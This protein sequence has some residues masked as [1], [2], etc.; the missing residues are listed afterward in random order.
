MTF[1]EN[2]LRARRNTGLL[3]TLYAAAVV[4]IICTIYLALVLILQ[5]T[6]QSPYAHQLQR[7]R[8]PALWH[9]QLFFTISVLTLTIILGG[10]L[11]KVWQLSAGG[12]EVAKL[13]G[14]RLIP[15]DTS[16]ANEK[17]VL[18]VVE[19]MS[20]AS[21][22]PVPAV[23][24]LAE[25]EEINAFAAGFST[26]DAVVAV[27]N[28][29]IQRL[30]RDE[31]QGVVAH[32]FSHILNGDMRLNLRLMG[33]L[34][35]ILMIALTGRGLL[36]ISRLGRHSRRAANRG[37]AFVAL[38]GFS[39]W[40]IG[41]IGAVFAQIIK[42]AVSRQRE[43]LADA[44][45]LQ[46]TRNPAGI[47][48]ALRKIAGYGS[49]LRH[50]NSEEAGHFFFA[51]GL[52][53][54]FFNLFATHPPILERIRRIDPRLLDKREGLVLDIKETKV[55][56]GLEE[57]AQKGK[58]VFSKLQPGDIHRTVGLVKAGHLDLARSL[59]AGLPPEIGK[60]LYDPDGARLVIYALLLN[61]DAA[62]RG[63]QITYLENNLTFFQRQNFRRVAGLVK[64]LGPQHRLP[65]ASAS[66]SA[67]R[68]L[69]LSEYQAFRKH[70]QFL[71]EADERCSV[72]EYALQR[73]LRRSLDR[74]FYPHHVAR[75]SPAVKG[76]EASAIHLLWC[77]AHL[78][79][80]SP[81]QARKAFQSGVNCLQ[82]R[83]KQED[84]IERPSLTLL[85]R[86]LS[87]LE[88]AGP[89]FKEK[90][91]KACVTVISADKAVS[92]EEAELIRAIADGLDCPIPPLS[93]A[94]QR[95]E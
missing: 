10:T 67:L 25:E 92:I 15:P 78:T 12:A 39:L 73:M 28:G 36:R 3:I 42:S 19:E 70:C 90:V 14:G 16:N 76:G 51:N 4:L 29:C 17:K 74:H 48:G 13:L 38:T 64:T 75:P 11:Y 33:V 54:T 91:L 45:A 9:P 27:T 31:L 58:P 6:L 18:N 5:A 7:I 57:E 41:Y 62:T 82:I 86:A 87:F 52:R 20:I 59:L 50:S 88:N 30:N 65:L 84:V 44:S 93:Q 81:E 49:K 47:G 77:L 22:V 60:F 89:L 53:E 32:E 23:Y 40:L 66:L 71:I 24:L 46:F 72:F 34:F 69:P 2:Q 94:G 8:P 37:T 68:F 26:K 61:R 55:H 85:D 80:S 35:G 1:F 79:S 43:Y 83:S 63:K 95:L 21:G 56:P